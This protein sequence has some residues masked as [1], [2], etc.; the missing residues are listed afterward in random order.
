MDIATIFGVI[1]AL[2][3]ILIS[4]I[5]SVYFAKTNS[6]LKSRLYDAEMLNKKKIEE[7]VTKEKVKIKQDLNER[8]RADM[9]SYKAV[10]KRI[11][12]QKKKIKELEEKVKV[13]NGGKKR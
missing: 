5:M 6:D 7:Q 12:L 10:Q 4:L 13:K 3:S 11:E 8:Y 2:T 1:L 9:V